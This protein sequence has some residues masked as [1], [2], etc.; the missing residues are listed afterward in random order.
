MT[1]HF[2]SKPIHLTSVILFRDVFSIVAHNLRPTLLAPRLFQTIWLQSQRHRL[3]PT[4]RLAYIRSACN[5]QRIPAFAGMTGGA[6]NDGWGERPVDT[7]GPRLRGGFDEG[8]G[9]S[10]VRRGGGCGGVGVDSD[11]RRNEGGAVPGVGWRIAV[12][13][14][15]FAG[16]TVGGGS[17]AGVTTTQTSPVCESNRLG[18]RRE[19]SPET[20]RSVNL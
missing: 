6:R 14:P 1:E 11:F 16:M 13:I 15:A 7:V 12:Q 9:D 10:G 8:A 2:I 19:A 3:L 5:E 18:S 17:G 20:G 4:E